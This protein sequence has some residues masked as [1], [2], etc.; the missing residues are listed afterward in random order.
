MKMMNEKANIICSECGS[1]IT[2]YNNQK[3]CKMCEHI[4]FVIARNEQED[5]EFTRYPTNTPESKD[6]S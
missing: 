4:E 6:C 2:Q 3:R 1:I 5:D